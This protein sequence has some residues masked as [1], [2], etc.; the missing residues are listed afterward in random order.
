MKF[1]KDALVF[2]SKDT[3]PI[4]GSISYQ[5]PLNANTVLN[6]NSYGKAV[7]I[8]SSQ[9]ELVIFKYN[10]H[11]FEF[12]FKN[13]VFYDKSKPKYWDKETTNFTGS[14]LHECLAKKE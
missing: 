1:I 4:R 3:A 6:V 10:D 9:T 12:I 2:L 11:A 7:K 8:T 5:E 14:K 13:N